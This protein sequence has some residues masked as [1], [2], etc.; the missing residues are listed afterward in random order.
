[1][2]FSRDYIVILME[3]GAIRCVVDGEVGY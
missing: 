1:L 3:V 2:L